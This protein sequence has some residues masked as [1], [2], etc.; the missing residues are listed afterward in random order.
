M[1]CL[2]KLLSYVYNSR[3][4]LVAS[5]FITTLHT[6]SLDYQGTGI[7]KQ[8]KPWPLENLTSA[9]PGAEHCFCPCSL[10]PT[11][12]S[13]FPTQS[14]K[15]CIYPT[16]LCDRA[17]PLGSLN[18]QLL[19]A[20]EGNCL[21]GTLEIHCWEGHRA[22]VLKCL[23]RLFLLLV[24]ISSSICVSTRICW[25]H[26]HM[27]LFWPFPICQQRADSLVVNTLLISRHDFFPGQIP[28]SQCHYFSYIIDIGLPF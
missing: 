8:N 5:F 18:R 11:Y 2:L 6:S 7:N 21:P 25:S 27:L 26:A 22:T 15:W 19:K 9:V 12:G 4:Y 24:Y 17:V 1:E 20:M 28:P 13:Y 3:C 16:S 23:E 10:I 14:S